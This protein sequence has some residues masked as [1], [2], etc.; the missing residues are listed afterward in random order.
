VCVWWASMY[1][2]PLFSEAGK[3]REIACF[4]LSGEN[5][6]VPKGNRMVT[7]PMTS[8]DPMTSKWWR[9]EDISVQL[10]AKYIED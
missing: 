7:L 1:V 9:H 8:R 3:L 2:Y 4:F 6:K 5:R 10:H